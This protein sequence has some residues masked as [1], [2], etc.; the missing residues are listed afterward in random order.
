MKLKGAE[1]DIKKIDPVVL[2]ELSKL[3]IENQPM[4]EMRHQTKQDLKKS[5]ELFGIKEPIRINQNCVIIAGR[6]RYTIAKEL[7]HK[8]VPCIISDTSENPIEAALMYDLEIFRRNL[9]DEQ[10][11]ELNEKRNEYLS[12]ITKLAIDSL[13]KKIIPD[14]R[15]AVMR[16]Y[17]ETGDLY[18]VKNISEKPAKAQAELVTKAEVV[19]GSKTAKETEKELQRLTKAEE[20]LNRDLSKLKKNFDEMKIKYGETDEMLKLLKEGMKQKVEDELKKREEEIKK[21]Y[22]A[23]APEQVRTLIKKEKQEIHE[24]YE[25]KVSDLQRKLDLMKINLREKGLEVEEL[26]D[27]VKTL[28]RQKKDAEQVKVKAMNDLETSKMIIS[29]L[30]QHDKFTAR[31]ELVQNDLNNILSGL[32]KCNSIPFNNEHREKMLKSLDGITQ[33]TEDLITYLK[34]CKNG[35]Y[36]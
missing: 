34:S 30:A 14:L 25:K 23:E 17:E 3:K 24:A 13:M 33:I 10:L 28:E 8:M 5:I 20:D 2:V 19:V 15:S 11:K 12:N 29:G 27:K 32:L 18:F 4:P 26:D 1:K 9:S 21:R 16:I 6:N 35:K 7:G 36:K 22:Q 31:V